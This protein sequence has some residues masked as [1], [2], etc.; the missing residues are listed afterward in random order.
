M[1]CI[2]LAP[3]GNISASSSSLIYVIYL[4]DFSISTSGVDI[5]DSTSVLLPGSFISYP[6][7][8]RKPSYTSYSMSYFSA[9][10]PQFLLQACLQGFIHNILCINLLSC[11]PK[12]VFLVP[13]Q[14]LDIFKRWVVSK[15]MLVN[16]PS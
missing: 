15:F 5:S 4:S 6:Y 3:S 14:T 9:I 13:T 2:N 7:D 11:C 16:L 1:S 8:I 12:W 10:S